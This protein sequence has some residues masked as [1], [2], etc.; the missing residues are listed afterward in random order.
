MAG[1]GVA[2][3]E[4]LLPAYRLLAHQLCE[5]RVNKVA[6]VKPA[7][8]SWPLPLY[9]LAL[10]TATECSRRGRSGLLLTV[11]SPRFLRADVGG[12][13]GDD[14][15]IDER[16]LW[17]PPN[18]FGGRYLAPYLSRQVGDAGDVMP[19]TTGGAG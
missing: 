17:W 16:A 13:A 6:F 3:L 10:L 9:D 18:K 5:G 19:L 2:A 11:G 8:P 14:S 15:A 12:G 7:G 1:G 4:T